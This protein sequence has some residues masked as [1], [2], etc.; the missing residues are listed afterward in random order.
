MKYR[1]TL[2]GLSK[3]PGRSACFANRGVPE[4]HTRLLDLLRQDNDAFIV[5]HGEGDIGHTYA[6]L[7]EIDAARAL[8]NA[9]P[10]GGSEWQAVLGTIQQLQSGLPGIPREQWR[11]T[12]WANW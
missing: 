4:H 11:V 3:A 6:G 10:I 5:K 9:P 2:F 7:H 12:V 1:R 8:P